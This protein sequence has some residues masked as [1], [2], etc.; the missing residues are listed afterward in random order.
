MS[1]CECVDLVYAVSSVQGR[2]PYNEDRL[3][4]VHP[5]PST[6]SSYFAVFD[7]HGGDECA[8]WVSQ[9]LHKHIV[10]AL[11]TAKD[12]ADAIQRGFISCDAALLDKHADGAAQ[13]GTTA[14]ALIIDDRHIITGNCGDTR[15]ILCR[16]GSVI[17]LSVDHKPTDDSERQR[18]E[19]AGGKVTIVEPPAAAA[20]ARKLSG[21]PLPIQAYVELGDKGIAVSR[22]FGN[23]SFKQNT[24]VP[25]DEQM[26][27][28]TPTCQITER[29]ADDQFVLLASD[30][31]WNFVSSSAVCT[32]ILDRLNSPFPNERDCEDIAHK[33]TQF[34]LNRKSNDNV[35]LVLIKFNNKTTTNNT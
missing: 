10:D 35:T 20:A 33:L 25:A 3:Q 1:N 14:C 34:A 17:E 28:V 16:N 8:E 22:A 13:S 4:C 31:L 6:N 27:I 32:F 30:G 23:V 5:L 19:A 2:R 11:P 12:T 21:R 26:I 7:G 18:I 15:A 29:S 9:H 24:T